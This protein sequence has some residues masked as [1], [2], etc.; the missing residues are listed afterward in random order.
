[1]NA[2]SNRNNNAISGSLAGVSGGTGFI[3]FLSAFPEGD[4]FKQ[5]AQYL[6][7]SIT[8]AMGLVWA[9]L[10]GWLK[11]IIED[12]Q[13]EAVIKTAEGE[14][15]TVRSDRT[16]PKQVKEEMKARVEVLRLLRFE[17]HTSR[18]KAILDQQSPT[19]DSQ[20]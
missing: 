7:P 13:L 10:I 14:Y 2:A 6:A 4:A 9:S 18:V 15:E 8:V 3:A 5:F 20:P 1:M 12:R 19:I 11:R 16:V 17:I